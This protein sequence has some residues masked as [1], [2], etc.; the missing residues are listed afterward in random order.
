M[1]IT[2]VFRYNSHWSI[3][4]KCLHPLFSFFSLFWFIRCIC[5]A[6]IVFDFQF[7]LVSVFFAIL[8]SVILFSVVYS[9]LSTNHF[10]FLLFLLFS[11]SFSNFGFLSK[12]FFNSKVSM[13]SGP[14]PSVLG[15]NMNANPILVSNVKFDALYTPLDDELAGSEIDMQTVWRSPYH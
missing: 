4:G 10:Y 3:C 1:R 15:P 6:I 8:F 7:S 5:F 9:Y 12:S 14:P 11:F 13:P 2:V